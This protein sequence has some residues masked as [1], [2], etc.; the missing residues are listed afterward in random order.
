MLKKQ[1]KKITKGITF[2]S[3]ALIISSCETTELEILDDPNALTPNQADIDLF[4]NSA[5]IELSTIFDREGLSELGMEVT[6]IL[7]GFGP[8][9]NNAYAPST[10]NNLWTI[11][12]AGILAD[13][14][15]IRPIAEEGQLYT[16]VGISQTLEAYVIMALVDYFGDIPY[17][18]ALN[19]AE[20]PNPKLDNGSDVYKEAEKLLNEALV[21]FTKEELRKPSS[22]LFYGGD[23][24]KWIK[25][26]N[27]VKLKLHLQT[28]LVDSEA[29]SKINALI[30]EG[31]LI[32]DAAD[33]FVFKYSATDANPDSR[34]PLFGRNF[35]AAADV[36]DYM[37]NSYMVLLKNDYISGDPRT[38]YYFYRQSL[39]FTTD[40][41]EN[42]CVTIARPTHYSSEDT[43][44][45]PGDGYWGRD[46][47]DNDGIPPD[48][49]KRTTWGVYPVGGQFDYNQGEAV[50]G[51]QIG[52]K[53]AGI[54][55]ILLSSFTNFML[56]E[57][58]LKSGVSGD[59][60]SYLEAGIR[61]SINKV[62]EL[63]STTPEM[64]IELV[65]DDPDTPENERKTV[66]EI[67][68][69]SSADIDLYIEKVLERYDSLS[70][71]DR[72]ELVV[73]EYFKALFGNGLEAYNTYR[74]T[75][76]PSNLQPALEPQP[77]EF[78]NS[79]FYPEELFQQNSNVDQKP[80]QA[81]RVF[82]A[83]GGP[84]VD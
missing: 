39:D 69:S 26:T 77:G 67:Y 1:I 18:E 34:H 44:C 57:A 65:A 28:R 64:E 19:G 30:S 4:L 83:E 82:W 68:G 15:A 45:N 63:G 71:D 84:T 35:D 76:F 20:F 53:G 55:P 5:E 24:S 8:T 6:R 11:S 40:P 51:R 38:R 37:S 78:I 36:S 81:V 27:T 42:E 59:P 29:G 22:D 23:K 66:R 72:L 14:R 10:T 16:H 7:H 13:L 43:Y 48:G 73:I 70:G 3:F 50:S 54:A 25:F 17:S 61:Q 75:G 21:N 31:N 80:N 62:I 52:L 58:S 33:D 47:F 74:R 2:L 32:L 46:H 56:A 12:Y 9:Y 41:N 79:F 49:G 60:K